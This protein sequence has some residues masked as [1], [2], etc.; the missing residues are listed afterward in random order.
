MAAAETA[1]AQAGKAYVALPPFYVCSAV[2]RVAAAGC[3][4]AAA[5]AQT[6]AAA[7]GAAAIH[8]AGKTK[9]SGRGHLA[10]PA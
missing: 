9:H 2:P 7:N 5:A 8:I 6:I 4:R 10:A 3:C 1:A